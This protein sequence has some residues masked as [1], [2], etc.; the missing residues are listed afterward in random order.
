MTN[1]EPSSLIPLYDGM[2]ISFIN[3][4]I[5]VNL[6]KKDP[7]DI[8]AEEQTRQRRVQELAQ[9]DKLAGTFKAAAAM[10]VV[11]DSEANK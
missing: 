9:T 4:E 8:D 7:N 10:N 5:R 2:V 1:H 11:E 3:Y 6:E